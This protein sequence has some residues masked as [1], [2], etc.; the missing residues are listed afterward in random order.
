M[1]CRLFLHW[2]NWLSGL[3]WLPIPWLFS[4]L[5]SPCYI[6]YQSTI[7]NF[8]FNELLQMP[9]RIRIMP[10][11]PMVVTIQSG[12]PRSWSRIVSRWF[13]VW[14]VLYLLQNSG[15]ICVELRVHFIHLLSRNRRTISSERPITV[16]LFLTPVKPVIFRP[17]LLL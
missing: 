10:D 1:P 8:S 6:L 3:H 11:R 2:L 9:A 12:I 14:L 17:P 5:L 16:I 13:E 4:G 7:L 15:P